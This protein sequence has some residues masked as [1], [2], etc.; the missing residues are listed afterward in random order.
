MAT[1]AVPCARVLQS[2]LVLHLQQ[3]GPPTDDGGGRLHGLDA[4]EKVL[5][6][7]GGEFF[8]QR[9]QFI[10]FINVKRKKNMA[11]FISSKCILVDTS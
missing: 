2:I 8:V 5:I 4:A 10:T 1:V 3:G 7:C 9:L 6:F 11:K